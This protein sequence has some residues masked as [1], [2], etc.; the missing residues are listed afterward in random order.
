[1]L[2]ARSLLILA[3]AAV[4]A[5]ALNLKMPMRRAMLGA[6]TLAV[7]PLAGVAKT[8]EEI[9]AES[10]AQAEAAAAA[11]AAAA[12]AG[13]PVGDLLGSVVNLGLSAVI[14]ALVGF[15]AKELF[16]ANEDASST[17]YSTFTRDTRDGYVNII[18]DKIDEE[19]K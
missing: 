8:M 11:K 4:P 1:M 12:Q 14:L 13:D 19:N 10:N 3:A 2:S 9:A 6:S 15:I 5:A 7:A 16:T 18:K 17:T